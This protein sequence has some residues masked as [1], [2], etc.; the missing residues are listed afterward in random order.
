MALFKTE[1]RIQ[2][3]GLFFLVGI[4]AVIGKLWWIQ[5]VN[6]KKYT[7]KI[8]GSGEVT[9]RI[10]SVRGEIRD[11]NGLVLVGNRP[12]FS[13]DFMLDEMVKG[14]GEAFGKRN[15][16]KAKHIFTV[17]GVYKETQEPD[18][19]KIVQETVL[20]RL[21]QLGLHED[22]SVKQLVKHYLH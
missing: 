21:D 3:I 20:P 18:V 13:V 6:H 8:R 11:R 10:P 17:G 19:A 7:D 4:S 2:I 5:V 22:F 14:Y 15:V 12:S 1:S 16:P 9:V